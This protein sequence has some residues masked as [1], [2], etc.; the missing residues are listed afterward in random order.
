MGAAPGDAGRQ[1]Q[2]GHAEQNRLRIAVRH[3]SPCH[4]LPGR[5]GEEEQG[6]KGDAGREQL[7]NEEK[8][9]DESRAARE[10]RGDRYRRS[11]CA[12]KAEDDGKA[13]AEQ[14]G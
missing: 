7:L 11:R 14:P 1:P 12:E 8:E 3:V 10:H 5:Q 6:E 4:V 13:K 9:D 2:R